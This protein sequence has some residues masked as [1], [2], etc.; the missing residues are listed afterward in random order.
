[1]FFIGNRIRDFIQN[2]LR[3][4]SEPL[5]IP[6]G[7]SVIQSELA[8]LTSRFYAIVVHNWNAF[9]RFYAQILEEEFQQIKIKSN[10]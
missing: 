2:A 7:M 5:R 3:Q 8:S 6:P 9:G 10:N 1:M 4:S